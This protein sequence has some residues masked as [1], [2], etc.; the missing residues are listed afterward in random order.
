MRK[1][2]Q[3]QQKLRQNMQK[4]DAEATENIIKEILHK[5]INRYVS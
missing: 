2:L 3:F 1:T 5:D 4:K